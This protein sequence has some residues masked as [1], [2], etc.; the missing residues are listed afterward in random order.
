[1]EDKRMDENWST[2]KKGVNEIITGK[3]FTLGPYFLNQLLHDPRHLLFTMSRYKFA[4]RMLPVGEKISILELGC[5]EGLGTQLLSQDGHRIT[6]V[7][8]D[9]D[10]INS[11]REI[12]NEKVTFLNENFLGK[13]YGSFDAV[14]SIDVVEHINKKQE[15]VFFET[16]IKNLNQHGFCII[17]TPNITAKK[18][19]S[20]YSNI[21]HINLYSAERLQKTMSK[22]FEHVFIF[23]MNDETLHTG[24]YSMCHYIFALGVERKLPE[25]K[26]D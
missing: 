15:Y 17:G 13:K 7:D 18:Y 12:P 4:A 25:K 10:A 20:K 24:Y 8:A 19:A 5:N 14:V 1:M 21:G 9:T 22:Y 23:G 11:A 26:S 2:I 16:I 3:E 6:A